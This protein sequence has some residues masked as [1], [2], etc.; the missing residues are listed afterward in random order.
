[1]KT[2]TRDFWEIVKT[3][4]PRETRNYVPKFIAAAIIGASPDEYGFSVKGIRKYPDVE[5][6]EIKGPV[7]LKDI[8]NQAGIMLTDLQEVNP[9]LTRALT[10]YNYKSYEV[11]VPSKNT[12]IL[13][14]NKHKIPVIK[15]A[16]NVRQIYFNKGRYVVKSGD[17]LSSISS[18]FKV[19]IK[20]LIETNK[21][22]G[23]R[24]YAGQKLKIGKMEY[25]SD[26]CLKVVYHVRRRDNLNKL[27]KIFKIPMR[28]IEKC[29]DFRSK[30]L[31]YVGQKLYLP[32]KVK[33]YK[34]KKGD[35]LG[36]IANLHQ[37]NIQSL[38]RINNIKDNR[39]FVG[40]NIIVPLPYI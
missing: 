5:L 15:V 17:T 39:I 3:N 10:P 16:Q 25:H 22:K 31:I 19:S 35:F 14:S 2:D 33:K 29:N 11:W 38:V 32:I 21:M 36:K 28:A 12:S 9:Q 40:D 27:S 13:E 37:A 4:L 23:V 8:A 30:R 18:K 7:Y 20:Q 24:I 26:N 34:V 6:V 1:M